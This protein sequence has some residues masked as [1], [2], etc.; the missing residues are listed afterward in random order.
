MA[1]TRTRY[2]ATH[3]ERVENELWEQS[4]RRK[5]TGY[6]LRKH[7]GIGFEG[8]CGH[9]FA[10][11]A[12]RDATPGPYWS[13]E[14]FGRTSTRLPD[15]RIIHIAGE[16]EDFYDSDFCIYNDVVIEYPDGRLEIYLYPRSVFPPTDFHTATLVDG[17]L[18]VIG[19]L[20]YMD[21]RRI[22]ETQ[23][24]KLDTRTLRIEQIATS[25]EGP[26]WISRH[27]AAR[28]GEAAVVVGGGKVAMEHGY[29]P[30]TGLFELDLATMIWRAREP[31]DEAEFPVPE[32]V[33]RTSKAPCRGTTNAERSDN[34]FWLEM[35]RRQWLPGRARLHFGDFAPPDPHGMSSGTKKGKHTTAD[36]VWTA[37]R[38]DTLQ[39]TLADGRKLLIGGRI[40][41]RGGDHA[42]AWTY[43]DAIVTHPDGAIE[44][45]TYP[46]D[47]F[48]DL[49]WPALGVVVGE[50][51]YVFGDLDWA[52]HPDGAQG[53]V[54]L[55]LDT[56]TYEIE[57]VY[58]PDPSVPVAMSSGSLQDGQRVVFP[59]VRRH[60]T[61]P[62]LGIAFD[63]ATQTWGEPFLLP[64]LVEGAA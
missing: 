50:H 35:A 49:L 6:W 53:P 43:N 26:G 40:P 18:I 1:G 5:G 44:I 17:E 61:D 45:L 16:H 4:I 51:V 41:D 60:S 64:P 21:L 38:E 7:L 29:G 10:H 15:G 36:I 9:N 55:Q 12:Y 33:Y 56:S 54:I 58:A 19:S 24:L 11:S 13:W 59:V 32:Q 8:T 30:N 27:F 62:R 2:G 23:V 20:G 57:P 31:G 46:K 39:L 42:D 3:P 52:G 48:P 28:I 37:V 34:P 63:L 47:I 22:G 14:R 25:G